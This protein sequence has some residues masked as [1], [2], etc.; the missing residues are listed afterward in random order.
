[1]MVHGRELARY[2]DSDITRWFVNNPKYRPCDPDEPPERYAP[3]RQT[4]VSREVSEMEIRREQGRG[5]QSEVVNPF[6]ADPIVDHGLGTVQGWKAAWTLRANTSPIDTYRVNDD[7]PPM[8]RAIVG[9]IVV[10]RPNARAWDNGDLLQ[11]DRLACHPI[12]PKNSNSRLLATA[13]EWAR[14]QGYDRVVTY[15]GGTDESN[16]G[17]CYQAVDFELDAVQ[18]ADSSGWKDQGEDRET[19]H[20]GDD[21][22]RRRWMLDL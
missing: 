18:A 10:G 14:D 19:I 21:W 20:D 3:M 2:L 6:L 7:H 16:H 13:V 12:R 22:Q 15:A 11:V 9:A 17:G 8:Q 4:T 1:M 5:S